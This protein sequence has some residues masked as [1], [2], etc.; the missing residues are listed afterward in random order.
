[1]KPCLVASLFSAAAFVCV[2]ALA[3]DAQRAKVNLAQEYAEC[4]AY[5]LIAAEGVRKLNS[6]DPL[7]ARLHAA[8]SEALQRS[9][10][11]SNEK[12]TG[13]RVHLAIDDLKRQMDY[14]YSN[15]AILNAKYGNTCKTGLT[16]PKARI[17]YWLEKK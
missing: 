16:N 17:K 9:I 15:M 4:A 8:E 10:N 2:P 6:A 11:L 12:V 14:S 7:I 3:Y 1:M 13:A 5:F